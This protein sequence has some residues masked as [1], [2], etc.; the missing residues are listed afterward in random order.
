MRIDVDALFAWLVE[1]WPI[2]AAVAAGILVIGLVLN[3]LPNARIATSAEFPTAGDETRDLAVGAIQIATSQGQWND[4][5]AH[6]IQ[7]SKS[8]RSTLVSMWGLTDGETWLE[9]FHELPQRRADAL[10]DSLLAVRAELAAAGTR[11]PSQREWL[12]AA[13]DRGAS[14]RE[15]TQIVQSVV[16]I[17]KSLKKNSL[18]TVVLP[19]E[20]TIASVRGY[21]QGQQVA[22]ATWGVA[23]GFA[24]REEIRP[25]LREVSA[26]ARSDFGSWE[27][28]GRSY[29]LGRTLRLVEQG[30][31][32]EK[33]IEKNADGL[34]AFGQLF[35]AKRGRSGP[36]STLT[37]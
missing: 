22:V 32:V 10:R 6:S 35:E 11:R 2:V 7:K 34:I 17:E 1:N 24:T 30:M 28:F 8:L 16:A 37:W 33:A 20:A 36:W 15:V 25:L 4:P 14:G 19:P 21:A 27:E 18:G 12:A 29:L 23:L 9:T 31:P 3:L 13:K 5:E 26:Q